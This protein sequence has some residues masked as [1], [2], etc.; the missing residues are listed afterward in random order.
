MFFVKKVGGGVRELGENVYICSAHRLLFVTLY[1]INLS[2][3]YIL[4][5]PSYLLLGL[6]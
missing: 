2:K 5:F 1:T 4:S 6:G 3:L